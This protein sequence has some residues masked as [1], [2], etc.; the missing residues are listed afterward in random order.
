MKDHDEIFCSVIFWIDRIKHLSTS[1]AIKG[2]CLLVEKITRIAHSLDCFTDL[3]KNDQNKLL[4]KMGILSCEKV[5]LIIPSCF[6]VFGGFCRRKSISRRQ[7]NNQVLYIYNNL[8][9]SCF[10]IYTASFLKAAILMHEDLY[11]LLKSKL[12]KKEKVK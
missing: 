8:L 12:K 9:I 2:C 4:K 7:L 11:M 10:E 6:I 5:N 3:P 1:A